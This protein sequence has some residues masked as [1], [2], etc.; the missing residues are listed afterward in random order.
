MQSWKKIASKLDE[1][2]RKETANYYISKHKMNK[3]AHEAELMLQEVE[4]ATQLMIEKIQKY[5]IVVPRYPNGLYDSD[6]LY[7]AYLPH[8]KNE[9]NKIEKL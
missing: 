8:L 6:A 1:M 2:E 5:T 3:A 7:K 9:I 4:G